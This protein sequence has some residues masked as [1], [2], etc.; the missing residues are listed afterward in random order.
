MLTKRLTLFRLFGFAVKIDASW[1]LLAVL[2][3]WSLARGVFPFYFPDQS[4]ATYWW[5][6]VGGAFGLFASIILHELGHALVAR[7]FG[8]PISDIT[9]FVFGGVAEMQDEPPS[10]KSE[11]LMA[12]AGP[13]TSVALGLVLFG[14]Y[15][16]V[17]AAG[18]WPAFSVIRYLAWLNIVLAIFNMLPAFPLDGGRVLRAGLWAARDN[19]R[20]AT[21]IASSIGSGFGI[22]LIVLGVLAFLTGNI[23]GGLW[24]FMIGMF[25]RAA[26]QMSYKQLLVRRALEGESLRRFI[27]TNPVTVPEDVSVRDLVEDYIYKF[28]FKFF[29]VVEDGQL[30]GCVSTKEVRDV[31]R[32]EWDTHS[33]REI[34]KSCA[35]NTVVQP[36]ED[37]L[38]VLSTMSRSGNTRLLVVE[39]DRLVGIVTLKDLLRFLS[40]KLDLEESEVEAN[41][42]VGGGPDEE[43]R[44]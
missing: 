9:L 25:M 26:S 20:W 28:H 35:V 8:I 40:L 21:R 42:G 22:V 32:E 33:V 15:G 39:N 5:M 41:A 3:T 6:A 34:L 16:S 27:Q 18:S 24:W 38:K 1:L 4:N 2:V 31:P 36:D 43:N 13:S 7:K 11:F 17:G 37:P 29:P 14:V 10:A 19:L 30:A 23:I 12:I 44:P